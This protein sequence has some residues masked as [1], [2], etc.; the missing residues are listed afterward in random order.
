MTGGI[1]D[2]AN[3]L[4]DLGSPLWHV[5]EKYI[6]RKPQPL[7]SLFN[8]VRP[9]SGKVWACL[10]V[11][12]AALAST[13]LIFNKI[14]HTVVPFNKMGLTEMEESKY[15]FY[16]YVF[17]RIVEPDLL[18]WFNKWSAGKFLTLVFYSTS[19]FLVVA[20]TCNLR[21]YMTTIQYETSPNDRHDLVALEKAV[22]I[23][24]ENFKQRYIGIQQ[25]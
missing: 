5:Q 4:F 24:H 10:F 22:Y 1:S 11:S 8:I 9:F 23:P 21:A 25:L 18:P 14:Y 17:T 7:K 3:L 19:T 15:L 2:R 12:L 16:L 6:T 13:L 20:Y